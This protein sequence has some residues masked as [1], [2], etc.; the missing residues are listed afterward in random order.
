[1]PIFP[2]PGLTEQGGEEA[3]AIEHGYTDIRT[4]RLRSD[5]RSKHLVEG[6]QR[7]T[8]KGRKGRDGKLS[9]TFGR[10]I[11][12]LAFAARRPRP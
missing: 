2:F 6:Q 5:V 9:G 10:Q 1:V 8:E 7:R 3:S 11:V 4:G 12:R